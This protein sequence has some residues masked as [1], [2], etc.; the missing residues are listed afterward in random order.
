MFMHFLLPGA[1]HMAQPGTG[2]YEGGVA[3]REAA[4]YTGTAADLPVEPF[5]DV[6]GLDTGPVFP[7]KLTVGQS[8]LNTIRYLPGN[9]LQLHGAQ[10]FYHGSGFLPGRFLALLGVDRLE[11]L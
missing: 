7:W 3:V 6:I 1:G 4:H 2:Q 5:N 11:H 9:L 8:L 10:F